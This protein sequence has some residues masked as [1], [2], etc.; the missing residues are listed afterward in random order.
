M[1]PANRREKVS[2]RHLNWINVTFFILLPMVATAGTVEI[3]LSGRLVW[4]TVWLAL[5]LVMLGCLS[6]TAGYHR[7]F[8][9]RAYQASKLLRW[10]FIFFGSATFEGSVLE[11]S[12]DHRDHHRFIDT[13][14]DPYNIREGFWYAHIGWILTLDPTRRNYSN[15]SDLQADPVIRFQHRHY[16]PICIITGFVLPALIAAL[17]GDLWGGL[18]IAGAVRIVLVQHITSL[19]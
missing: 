15:V 17:W 6:I 4:P 18:V 2:K 9:H 12:C 11:W 5:A 3:I 8:S 1:W 13:A 14:R 16:T 19:Y 10:F 7:L